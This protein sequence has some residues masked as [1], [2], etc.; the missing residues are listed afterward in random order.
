MATFVGGRN[1]GIAPTQTQSGDWFDQQLGQVDT[2]QIGQPGTNSGVVGPQT[3]GGDP[4]QLIAQWQ[5]SHPASNPD[6]PGLVQLLQQ[7]GV[8]ATQATHAGGQ[9]SDDKIIIGGGMYDLGSSLGGG[10]AS[11]FS[12]PQPDM[13]DPNAGGT[14]SGAPGGIPGLPDL[15]QGWTTPFQSPGNFTAPT[16]EQATNSPGFQFRLKEGID[17]LQRSASARGTLLTGGT[18]KDINSWAQDAASQE[19]DKVYNRALGENNLQYGR[20]WNEY[21]DQEGSFY[22]NQ[23]NAFNRYF[24]LAGLGQRA[25]SD[26]GNYGNSYMQQGNGLITGSGNA[27][28]AGTVGASNAYQPLYGDAADAFQQW[29]NSRNQNTPTVMY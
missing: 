18:L 26:L 27:Q 6:I 9:L 20:A 14:A 19:Y 28:A 22:K 21:G 4:Q 16:M 29:W 1:P 10:D 3:Q 12:N 7:N 11:W 24:S 13:N 2:S 25:A 15:T 17:A 23:D 8:Q 5:Q